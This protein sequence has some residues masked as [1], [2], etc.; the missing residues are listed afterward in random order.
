MKKLLTVLLILACLLSLAACGKTEAAEGDEQLAGGIVAAEGL[1]DEAKEA[2]RKATEAVEG[3]DY[4]LVEL[5][6]TQ[7][8]AGINYVFA[9]NKTVDGET[10]RVDITVYADLEGNCEITNEVV[11]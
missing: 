10:V 3:A 6:S 7:V 1:D 5:K 4:E 9:A 11:K 8:V 2:F